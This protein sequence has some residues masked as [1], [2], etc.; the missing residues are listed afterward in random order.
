[1]YFGMELGSPTLLQDDTFFWA[2]GGSFIAATV[3]VL[4]ISMFTTKIIVKLL[5]IPYWAYAAIILGVIIWS[6]F[7]YTGTINDFYILILCSVLG[8]A[9]KH[10]E[11]S[12]PAVMV[13]FI[14]VDRLE[15]YAIQ[16]MA[17]FKPEELVVRPLFMGLLVVAVGIV[18]YSI[19]RPGK[20][21][22]YH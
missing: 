9:C 20:G 3:L 4:F 17:L 18:I 1:M 5:E 16:T 7:E 8:I 19:L 21:L 15:K 6:C 12:R 14:L 22:E 13:A 2:L 10:F 11:I